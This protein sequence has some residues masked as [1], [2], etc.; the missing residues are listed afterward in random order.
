MTQSLT[1]P[2]IDFIHACRACN[3]QNLRQFLT[4]TLYLLH[5]QIVGT[6]NTSFPW[7]SMPY[8]A[9]MWSSILA[10]ILDFAPAPRPRFSQWY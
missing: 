4:L 10:V 6:A 3:G 2:R 5:S 1:L 9:H 8:P 7:R